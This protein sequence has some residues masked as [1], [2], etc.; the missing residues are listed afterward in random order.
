MKKVMVNVKSKWETRDVM[1][2]AIVEDD[3]A[4]KWESN[5]SYLMDDVISKV[6]ENGFTDFSV[7]AT[8]TKRDAQ[9]SK[10]IEEY[11]KRS[12]SYS[13]SEMSEMRCAFGKGAKVIDV[14]TGQEINL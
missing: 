5:G 12:R 2:K 1:F 8:R 11:K 10:E 9:V 7:E 6:I 13:E 4:I 14:L 3:G